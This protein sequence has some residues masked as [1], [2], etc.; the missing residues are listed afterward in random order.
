M[1]VKKCQNRR[2]GI[3]KVANQ[4]LAR[5]NRF[6]CER[7]KEQEQRAVIDMLPGFFP[8]RPNSFSAF[9]LKQ[10]RDSES[11]S[12]NSRNSVSP[13]QLAI[14][15]RRRELHLCV[16]YRINSKSTILIKTNTSTISKPTKTPVINA[17][18]SRLGISQL[19]LVTNRHTHLTNLS[20]E[21]RN[22]RN[23]S[24]SCADE[25]NHR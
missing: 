3:R 12:E 9:V 25:M 15:H 4:M 20:Y 2:C 6:C 1:V 13:P 8:R 22:K 19:G 23:P 5:D 17:C 11:R 10:Q 16:F 21:P 24:T 14:E 7:C 18:F